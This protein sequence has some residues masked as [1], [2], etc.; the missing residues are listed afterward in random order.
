[1]KNRLLLALAA[2]IALNLCSCKNVAT[3]P[4]SE[5]SE[6]CSEN[7]IEGIW[8][9]REDTNSNNFYE[10]YRRDSTWKKSYHVRFWNRGGTNPTY[11]ANIH[12]SKIGQ[13]MFIN[14]P[15]WEFD[16]EHDN[17]SANR[18]YGFL[19]I[20][21]HNETFDQMTVAPVNDSTM[22]YLKNSEEVRAYIT[23]NLN[24]PAFYQTPKHFYKVPVPPILRQRGGIGDGKIK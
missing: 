3:Y 21:D 13:T 14:V 1:M 12:F 16:E 2:V 18:G 8:K 9:F 20:L 22:R 15:Y 6:K 23:K 4:I 24:N 10:V 19:K 17:Y 5:P 11:E 7:R